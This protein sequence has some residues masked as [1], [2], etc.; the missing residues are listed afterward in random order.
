MKRLTLLIFSVL[1]AIV[2]FVPTATMQKK[3]DSRLQRNIS[4]SVAVTEALPQHYINEQITQHKVIL[5]NENQAAY[6]ELL[7]KGAIVKEIDY[8]TFKLIIVDEN[9]LG[10][11][12]G[13]KKLPITISDDQDLIPL[14][15]Y[16]LNTKNPETTYNLLPT[17]LRQ[18]DTLE[19]LKQGS[20][21]AKGG[22]Y[23]VQFVGPIQDEWL[24]S[25]K[26]NGLEIVSYI[27]SN[28]YV[29]KV[30]GGL[31]EKLP[32]LLGQNSFVQFVGSY[33]PAFR[34]SPE[35]RIMRQLPR[36]TTVD[37]IIQVVDGFEARDTIETLKALATEFVSVQQVLNYHN[38]AIKI[39]TD[40][41]TQ[42]AHL[43]NIFAIE[44][45]TERK[46]LDEAQGQI[47]AN[48]LSGSAP[49]G[50][51]YLSW[52][53]SKGFTSSQFTS[54]AVNVVDDSALLTGHP[55]VVNTRVVFQNNPTAQTGQQG[56]H[57]FLNAHIIGGLN[58]STGSAFEDANGYNY[59]LGIAPYTRLGV[60]AIFGTTAATPTNWENTAY[61]QGAR[62]SSNSWGFIGTANRKYNT[63]AQEF[64]RIVRDA[65]NGTAGLQQLTV[66][67][68][69]GNDGDGANTVGSPA[70]AKN[71]ITVGASENFRQTGTDG[72]AVDNTGA[73]N[74]N[75][76]INFSSRG[77]VN[78]GGGDGRIKPDIMAPG[79]H[80]EAGIPQSNYDGTS[81]CDKYFPTGQT[82][83][84]WS[85]GTSHACP[86]VAGGAA[87]VYQDFLNKSLSAP[88]PAMVKAHLMNS[89]SYMN[90]VG[91]NDT[92][93]SNN[94]GM[95]RMNLGRTFDAVPRILV[96]QTQTLGA[97]GQTYQVTGSVAN[98]SQP[99]RVTLAWTDAPGSVTGAPWVNNLDLEVTINGTTYKGNVFSGANSVTGGSADIKN[100]SESVFIPAG[101]SGNFT[102]TVKATNIAGDGVPGNADTTDQDFALV[103][104]NAN[105][106]T[107]TTPTIAVSPSSLSFTATLG[108][109]NPSNQ[110][111][112][113]SN[114]GSGTLSWSVSDNASWLTLSPTSGTAPSSTTASVNISGLAVGTYNATITITSSGATNSPISIPVTLTIN[115]ASAT[116]LITNGGFETSISPWI[117]SGTGALY[118]ANGNFPQA[119]TGYAYFG[120]ANSVTG[121]TYQT[122]TIPSGASKT[123]TFYLNV[124]SAETT[125]STQYDRLFV[126]VRNSAGTL[127][128][129]LAT[130]S[131]LDKTTSGAYSQKTFSLANYAGQTVRIQFRTTCDSSSITTFRLDTVSVK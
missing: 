98:S 85:S 32:E 30:D 103:V 17:D 91:A 21:S 25:L 120:A 75:D 6:N 76:I 16:I 35:L 74:V 8:G 38:V 117:A 106:T 59:G 104:Y 107:Q 78:S 13:L 109:A 58:T 94:Q 115:S 7:S 23:I 128:G 102:V 105:T 112:N 90:G 84:G 77:P 122:I 34:I 93:P 88:S 129:T 12:A 124:T 53:A 116:E 92:L 95:G 9:S 131:N 99:F 68:A 39:E 49:S 29:V 42:I 19:A 79:T 40:K 52:L 121:Q 83:Y 47:L 97:T 51:G 50:P 27:P 80:I 15:G 56:G 41:L 86:A 127:L 87:L 71:V 57:G 100:N 82:L 63:S 48:N 33:E 36:G 44:E 126:E 31:A 81:V 1:M 24:D 5:S 72:C 37:V 111:L 45:R 73:N 46:R 125:T 26:L 61:G 119:G 96:D 22:M 113:I 123:L 55:D 2:L 54:F 28:A 101:V 64:D 43:D 67:F 18:S 69:A 20:I 130:Y 66:V 4:P 14:N 89:T 114:S 3:S 70:T 65:Q 60:T 10:G 11:K 110:S 62:I 118:V 108:S